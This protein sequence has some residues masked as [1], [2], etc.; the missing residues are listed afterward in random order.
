MGQILKSYNKI[1]KVSDEDVIAYLG[2]VGVK[3]DW[4]K[5]VHVM[6]KLIWV[7]VDKGHT[8]L[9]RTLLHGKKG[10]KGRAIYIALPRD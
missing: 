6:E 10:W 7:N 3:N 1:E 2:Q 5:S 4:I 9:A 8:N